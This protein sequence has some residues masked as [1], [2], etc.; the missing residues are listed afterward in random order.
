MSP[1]DLDV[2]KTFQSIPR[3]ILKAYIVALDVSTKITPD[4]IEL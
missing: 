3:Y 1:I 4:T 2:F